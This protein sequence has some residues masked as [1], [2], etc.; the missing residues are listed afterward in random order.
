MLRIRYRLMLL[1][2]MSLWLSGMALQASLQVPFDFGAATF[3]PVLADRGE[4]IYA[5]PGD[6]SSLSPLIEEIQEVEESNHSDQ[7]SALASGGLSARAGLLFGRPFGKTQ[8]A[9]SSSVSREK[10]FILYHQLKVYPA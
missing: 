5:S 10:L 2:L 1:S 3:Q 9:Q 7:H 6:F 4:E 8:V